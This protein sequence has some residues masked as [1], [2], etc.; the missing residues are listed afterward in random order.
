MEFKLVSVAEF[1]RR[2][3]CHR[4]TVLKAIGRGEIQTAKMG[5]IWMIW[6]QDN[7]AWTPRKAGNPNWTRKGE[8]T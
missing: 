7:A 2:R 5:R 6:E 4:R 8:K 3:G 1:A